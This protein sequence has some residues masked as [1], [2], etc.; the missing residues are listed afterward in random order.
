MDYVV[1][2]FSEVRI[3]DKT[4]TAYLARRLTVLMRRIS[5][6]IAAVSSVIFSTAGFSHD[7]MTIRGA[8]IV[9]PTATSYH[10]HGT[11]HSRGRRYHLPRRITD[12]HDEHDC[13]RL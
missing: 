2:G 4:C 3:H 13:M 1:A 11:P 7:V 10:L 9:P 6:A 8:R 12:G 5:V